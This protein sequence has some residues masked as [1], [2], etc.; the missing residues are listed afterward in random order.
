MLIIPCLVTRSV[1]HAES[2]EM[3]EYILSKLTKAIQ[4]STSEGEKKAIESTMSFEEKHYDVIKKFGRYPSR[5]EAMEREN[6]AEEIESLKNGPG[7]Q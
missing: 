5:N 3:H 2:P 6:T 1:M 4:Q 7:W